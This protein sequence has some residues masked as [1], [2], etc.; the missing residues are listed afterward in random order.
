MKL[1]ISYRMFCISWGFSDGWADIFVAANGS[2]KL[3]EIDDERRLRVFMDK[4]AR[5]LYYLRRE[6]SILMQL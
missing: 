6:I 1:N 5:H 3:I 4:Y 2:Q